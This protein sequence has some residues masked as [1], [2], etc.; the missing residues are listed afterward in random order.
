MMKGRYI[1]H[2]YGNSL[3]YMEITN[4]ESCDPAKAATKNA[5]KSKSYEKC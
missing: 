2:D 1:V 4:L 3:S 5:A